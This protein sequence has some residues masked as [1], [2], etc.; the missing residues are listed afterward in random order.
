MKNTVQVI[1]INVTGSHE[2]GN[3]DSFKISK[4]LI[5]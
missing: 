2:D 3:T 1:G 4:L 5:I